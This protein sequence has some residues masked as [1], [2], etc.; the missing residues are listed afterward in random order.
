MNPFT[1]ILL[2]ESLLNFQKGACNIC[3]IPFKYYHYRLP[4][5]MGNSVRVA[6]GVLQITGSNTVI[7]TCIE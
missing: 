6:S 2:L 4:R 1:E 3:H 5:K 7:S